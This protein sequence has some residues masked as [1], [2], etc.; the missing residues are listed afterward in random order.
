MRGDGPPYVKIGRAIRYPESGL[1][2]TDE[3]ADALVDERT[4]DDFNI[5]GRAGVSSKETNGLYMKD[6]SS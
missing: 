1:Q 4:V 3:S 2:A 6:R 5:A